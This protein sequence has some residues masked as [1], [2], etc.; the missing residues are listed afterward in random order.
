MS[1]IMVTVVVVG[2]PGSG[3]DV[4]VGAAKELGFNHI[5]MGDVVREYAKNAGKAPDDVSVGGF[6]TEERGKHG[7]EIWAV[8]TLENLPHGNVIID[9]SRSLAEI[10][11]FISACDDVVVMG[12]DAPDEQRF[13]RL[14]GRG[15]EDDPKNEKDFELRD[16]REESWGIREALVSA[17]LMLINAGSLDGFKQRCRKALSGLI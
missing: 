2:M 10:R 4:L 17:D 16:K 6:A 7:D 15:R 9:G 3:K 14:R 11:H 5:R 12:I 8:R 13:Q 1:D